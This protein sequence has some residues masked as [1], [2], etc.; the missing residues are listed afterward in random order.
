VPWVIEATTAAHPGA[1]ERIELTGTRGTASLAGTALE[2]RCTTAAAN[3]GG[4]RFG[5]RRRRRS[6]GVPAR[7]SP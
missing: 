6:N 2:L 4:G 1:A 7:L 5:G 3:H